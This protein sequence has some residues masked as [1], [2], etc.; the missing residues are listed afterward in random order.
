[1]LNTCFKQLLAYFKNYFNENF[2]IVKMRDRRT[3][4]DP[5]SVIKKLSRSKNHTN[6]KS[7]HRR[8]A[9]KRFK[10]IT[11]VMCEDCMIRSSNNPNRLTQEGDFYVVKFI[12]CQA[13]LNAGSCGDCK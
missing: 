13:C 11:L 4:K 5:N 9:N 8:S 3:L 7:R 12:I 1:M 2:F 10:N 6:D